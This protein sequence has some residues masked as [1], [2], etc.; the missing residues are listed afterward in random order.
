MRD[1]GRGGPGPGP[2]IR[3]RDDAGGGRR[4]RRSPRGDSELEDP[5]EDIL[6]AHLR[7][8]GTCEPPEVGR[9]AEPR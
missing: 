1:G 4:V 8:Y 7:P 6:E 2:R 3:H 9:G 5:F